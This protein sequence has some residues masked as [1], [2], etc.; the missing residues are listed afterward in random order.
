MIYFDNHTTTKPS[1]KAIAAMR[2]FLE[3]QWGVPAA[4]HRMG[5]A[6]LPELERIYDPIYQLLG[7]R[8]SDNFVF[9]SSGAEASNHVVQAA[10]LDIAR[11][12]GRNHFVTTNTD[13]AAVIMAYERLELLGCK[14]TLAPVNA[15]GI[16]TSDALID[17]LTP[18]TALVSLSWAN[19]LTG[20]IHPVAELAEIC[21]ER[22]IWLHLDATHILGKIDFD[23]DEIAPDLIT[24][25]GDH[26]HAPKGTGGLWIRSGLRLSN[27]ILGGMEQDGQRGG[28]YSVAL[29]AALGAACEEALTHRDHVA[30][31]TARLR[32][33][34]EKGLEAIP[35][36]KTTHR[37]PTTTALAFPGV[38]ADALLYRLS[39]AGL[40][41][42]FGGGAYQQLALQ[43]AATGIPHPLADCAVSF[44]LSRD[45]TPA[46]ID[47]AIALI[48]KQAQSLQS[49]SAEIYA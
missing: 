29:L 40:L 43:L 10:Y 34:L 1:A 35:F 42:S 48:T 32:D 18:R 44:S 14:T 8:S 23:L 15:D 12:T 13:E 9:T 26:L 33:R 25:N 27:L 4:P 30:I 16:L 37:T 38:T 41:A 17:S 21:R 22:G 49:L 3:E 19:G 46:D 7:A 28:S 5:Q 45:T 36:F 39:R 31:E 20:V 2:P 47:D 6:L 24:F 11:E